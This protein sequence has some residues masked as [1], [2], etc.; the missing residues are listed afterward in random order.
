MRNPEPVDLVHA[1]RVIYAAAIVAVLAL[2]VATLWAQIIARAL[3]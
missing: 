2:A 1:H 3:I